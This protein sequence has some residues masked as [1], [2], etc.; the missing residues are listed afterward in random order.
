[1]EYDNTTGLYHTHARYYSPVLDRFLS[2]DPMRHG[3]GVNFFTYADNNPVSGT[4]PLG[5]VDVPGG[6]VNGPSGIPDLGGLGGI[7]LGHMIESG[8]FAFEAFDS[9]GVPGGQASNGTI[10]GC[11]LGNGCRI[12]LPSQVGGPFWGKDPG[13]ILSQEEITVDPPVPTG[14]PP[15]EPQPP[16]PEGPPRLASPRAPDE[17]TGPDEPKTEHTKNQRPSTKG[18][19]EKGQARKKIDTPGN[20]KGDSRRPYRNKVV[21]GWIEWNGGNGM[22]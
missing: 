12:T 5:L 22:I 16:A 14:D 6:D 9:A 1:M 2:E 7:S 10:G 17:P 3:A 13:I 15:I 21:P 4:D 20:E 18:K 19:H 8:P 11:N